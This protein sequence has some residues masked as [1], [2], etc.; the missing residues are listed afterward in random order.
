MLLAERG[1]SKNSAIAYRN[2]LQDFDLYLKQQRITDLL[3]VTADNIRAFVHDLSK[4]NIASR[5]IARKLSGI[6]GFYSFLINESLIS[7]N[8]AQ[9]IDIP[10]YSAPLPAVLSIEEIKKM[11]TACRETNPET[12]RLKCMI[13]LLYATGLRV[14]ELVSMKLSNLS[15]N[16]TTGEMRNNITITGKGN[17]ERIVIINEIARQALKDYLPFREFFILTGK[18]SIYLFPS[19]SKQGYMT[20]QNFALLLKKI[21]ID[22]GIDP[23]KVSP[24]VLRHSFASHLLAGGADLRVIQELLGHADISTTQIYTHVQV[25]KLKDIMLKYHPLK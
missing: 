17:K 2:D 8:P 6:R 9:L 1:L 19:A 12:V 22:S 13:H 24:H 15:L 14:S 3:S 25:D 21:A 10:K 7:E 23:E 4:H 20:R 5:S 18:T 16:Q 11:V